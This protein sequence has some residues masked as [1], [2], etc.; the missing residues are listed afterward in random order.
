[1]PIR[2]NGSEALMLYRHKRD[3]GITTGIIAAITIA[4]GA[5]IGA[6]FVLSGHALLTQADVNSCF[7]YQQTALLQEQMDFLFA[8]RHIT[9]S[10]IFHAIC[11]VPGRVANASQQVLTLNKILTSSW[12]DS[13]WNLT[14][15]LLHQIV[16]INE[17]WVDPLDG[18]GFLSLVQQMGTLV[19]EWAGVAAFLGI[20]LVVVCGTVWCL[21]QLRRQQIHS[22]AVV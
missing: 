13:Y 4:T 7:H 12:N 2:T 6:G 18:T 8:T 20:L 19:K 10:P 17:T 22:Q 15:Q 3:F 9:C 14:W 16:L 5:A 21:L 11:V 1:M